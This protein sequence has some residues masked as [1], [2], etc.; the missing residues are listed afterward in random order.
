MVNTNRRTRAVQVRSL[1]EVEK[2]GGEARGCA[3]ALTGVQV[4]W[5]RG[6]VPPRFFQKGIQASCKGNQ[7]PHGKV[8]IWVASGL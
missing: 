4:E 5:Q 8:R 2:K 3:M 6:Q 7:H 1:Q